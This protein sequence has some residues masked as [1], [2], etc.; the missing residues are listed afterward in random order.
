MIYGI[1]SFMEIQAYIHS[2]SII[3]EDFLQ[4]H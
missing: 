1:H 2:I 3:V 4:N